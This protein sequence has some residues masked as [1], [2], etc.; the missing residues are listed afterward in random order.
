LS[1]FLLLKVCAWTRAPFTW[2]K[3]NFKKLAQNKKTDV[4][5]F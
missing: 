1:L 3:Y 4:K 5:L 2:F